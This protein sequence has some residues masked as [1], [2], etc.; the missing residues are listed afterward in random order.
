MRASGIRLAARPEAHA[1]LAD[2]ELA[3]L[4]PEQN[5]VSYQRL[6][7]Q[8]PAIARARIVRVDSGCISYTLYHI[9]KYSQ[10]RDGL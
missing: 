4:G 5:F 2:F 9:Q 3:L 7:Q 8:L 6:I 10:G 1:Q